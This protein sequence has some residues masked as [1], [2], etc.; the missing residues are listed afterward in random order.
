M[1][2]KRGPGEGYVWS[3][4]LGT[5]VSA[6]TGKPAPPAPTPPEVGPPPERTEDYLAWADAV[7]RAVLATGD[8][9]ARRIP[10]HNEADLAAILEYDAYC[11]Y[12]ALRG[13][14]VTPEL[15]LVADALRKAWAER[16]KG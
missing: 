12:K 16:E 11:N 4:E 7:D 14:N 1:S 15:Q 10:V 5:L 13:W 2:R 9:V 3:K 6:R 8:R